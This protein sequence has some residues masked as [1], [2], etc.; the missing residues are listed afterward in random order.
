MLVFTRPGEVRCGECLTVNLAALCPFCGRVQ[1]EPGTGPVRC[2]RCGREY[3]AVK[4]PSCTLAYFA[5]DPGAAC[6]TCPG[7]GAQ[8]AR[9]RAA[10]SRAAGDAHAARR[11]WGDAARAYEESLRHVPRDPAVRYA[12]ACALS[13]AGDRGRA[14]EAL[15]R[16][17][18][19]G[20]SNPE[21]LRKDPDLEPLRSEPRY[22]AL[23]EKAPK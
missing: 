22:R 23:L 21:L 3:R 2:G 7:P 11:E 13:R 10:A 15:E 9:A 16:A 12:L 1:A 17:V 4:C 8:E 5:A 6:P 14:L 19:D 18:A 20:F